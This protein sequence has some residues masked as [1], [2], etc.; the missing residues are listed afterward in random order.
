MN[1]VVLLIFFRNTSSSEWL[2]ALRSL[3]SSSHLG[4]SVTLNFAGLCLP[5]FTVLCL[6]GESGRTAELLFCQHG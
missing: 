5:Q 2:N 3:C 6:K 4:K 1:P